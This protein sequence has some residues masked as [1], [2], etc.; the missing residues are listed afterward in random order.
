MLVRGA[1]GHVLHVLV[2]AKAGEPAAEHLLRGGAGQ[3]SKCRSFIMH[4]DDV[5]LSWQ[6][7]GALPLAGS[8]STSE[9]QV[10]SI[11]GGTHLIT[12]ARTDDFATAP[13]SCQMISD[14]GAD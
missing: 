11:D 14:A 9:N 5:G 10:A 3:S 12:T 7:S 8:F 2:P 1:A 13:G 6:H 4:S